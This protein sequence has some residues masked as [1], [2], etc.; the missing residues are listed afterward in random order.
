MEFKGWRDSD[1]ASISFEAEG[2]DFF[3]S[4]DLVVELFVF[5][6]GESSKS[7]MIFKDFQDPCLLK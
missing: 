5:E 3:N 1:E 4:M 2:G 7:R 6:L